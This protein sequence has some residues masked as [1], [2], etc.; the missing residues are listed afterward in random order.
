MAP[1]RGDAAAAARGQGTHPPAY[2]D[3]QWGRM[4]ALLDTLA[5]GMQLLIGLLL[6]L[7]TEINSN[8][9]RNNNDGGGI[10]GPDSPPQTPP[11]PPPVEP[12]QHVPQPPG[13]PT[14]AHMPS[15]A[16]QQHWQQPAAE[17]QNTHHQQ[18]QGWQQRVQGLLFEDERRDGLGMAGL[19]C[20]ERKDK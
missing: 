6:E 14:E 10:N 15:T 17:E 20:H 18:R 19:G 13:A 7:L 8:G 11:P 5:G 12:Q 9:I 4:F 16:A 1:P 3:R 2:Y